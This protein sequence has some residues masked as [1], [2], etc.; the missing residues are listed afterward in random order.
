MTG[1]ME[2]RLFAACW[3]CTLRLC[4]PVRRFRVGAAVQRAATVPEQCYVDALGAL[5]P[6]RTRSR[7]KMNSSAGSYPAATSWA[8]DSFGSGNSSGGSWSRKTS[9]LAA[10]AGPC[11]WG[12]A[13]HRGA[14][15]PGDRRW[16][17]ADLRW[18]PGVRRL[19][20]LA[21]RDRRAPRPVVTAAPRSRRRV[22]SRT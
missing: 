1:M 2:V 5:E 22:P 4:R 13:A 8:A 20:R 12:S 10:P 6:A 3:R 15:D 16:L 19:A 7:P 17:G 9:S 14:R 11:R 21:A 18:P